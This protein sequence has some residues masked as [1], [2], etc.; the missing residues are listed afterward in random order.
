MDLQEENSELRAV[1]DEVQTTLDLI[2]HKHRSQ[3]SQVV[4]ARQ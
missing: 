2:M 3:V 1:L 4:K